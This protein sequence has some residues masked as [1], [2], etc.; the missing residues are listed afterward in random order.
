VDKLFDLMMGLGGAGEG[1]VLQQLPFMPF[2]V[3]RGDEPE[4]L[5]INESHNNDS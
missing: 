4:S 1:V 3:K 5:G 2:V